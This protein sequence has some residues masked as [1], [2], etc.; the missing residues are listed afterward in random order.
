MRPFDKPDNDSHAHAGL[1][2]DGLPLFEKRVESAMEGRQATEKTKSPV[3]FAQGQA[4]L[5]VEGNARLA[6]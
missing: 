4:I 5:N 1:R 6:I 3:A 2:P